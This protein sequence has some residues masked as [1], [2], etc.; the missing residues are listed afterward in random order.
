METTLSPEA[1]ARFRNSL[2]GRGRSENTIRAY[3]S[4]LTEFLKWAKPK[5]VTGHLTPGVTEIVFN[6]WATTWLNEFRLTLAPKTTARRLTSLKAWAK[7]A[8]WTAEE[9]D[10]YKAPVPGKPIAHPIP[11]G[12][13]AVLAMAEAARNDRQRALVALCGLCGLRV[14]EALA[15]TPSCFNTG[16][17]KLTVRGK[18]DKERT[19]PVSARAWELISPALLDAVLDNHATVVGY[20]DRFARTVLTNL[21]RKAG[22]SRRVASHDLRATFGTAVYDGTLDLRVTQELLGHASSKTTEGY[23]GVKFEKMRAAAE[24]A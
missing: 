15:V 17:M 10:E 9:L 23:T 22:V 21:G 2:C 11:E 5:L 16:E 24:I 6:A 7:W 20:H 4:D 13:T 19:V 3:E 14:A 1:I 12:I 8:R 18:G